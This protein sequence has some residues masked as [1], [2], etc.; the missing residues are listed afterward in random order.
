MKRDKAKL[1][2][3]TIRAEAAEL[4][5]KHLEKQLDVAKMEAASLKPRAAS[6]RAPLPFDPRPQA[7]AQRGALRAADRVQEVHRLRHRAPP[8]VRASLLLYIGDRLSETTRR[9]GRLRG[10]P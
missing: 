4:K 8:G 6:S 1:R 7:P 5:A 2:E 3:A 9:P 10:S